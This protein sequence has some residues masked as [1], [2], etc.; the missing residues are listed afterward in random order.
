MCKYLYEKDY[1]NGNTERKLFNSTEELLKYI[2]KEGEC[3]FNAGFHSAEIRLYR[4]G[5]ENEK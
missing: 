2:Q 3:I 5:V 1:K 4:I